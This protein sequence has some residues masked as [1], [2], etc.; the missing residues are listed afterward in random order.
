MQALPLSRV[1]LRRSYKASLKQLVAIT[2]QN[3]PSRTYFQHHSGSKTCFLQLPKAFRR[4][5][6]TLQP[7]FSPDFFF[8]QVMFNFWFTSW[9]FCRLRDVT[10][11]NITSLDVTPSELWTLEV[12][13]SGHF[14]FGTLTFR[15][16]SPSEY[17]TFESYTFRCFTFGTLHLRNIT[18]SQNYTFHSFWIRLKVK[19]P[20]V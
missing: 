17:Y 3:I 12:W 14:T 9:Q 18:T 2:H 20:K 4:T 5:M 8:R 6:S 1:V 15:A 11:S 7:T 13:T 10:P 16:V 19:S